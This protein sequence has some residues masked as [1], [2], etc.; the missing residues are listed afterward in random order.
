MSIYEVF[1]YIL[2]FTAYN[3]LNL[4]ELIVFASVMQVVNYC[5]ADLK[6]LS[7]I[8]KHRYHTYSTG[9]KKNHNSPDSSTGICDM[10]LNDYLGDL[11]G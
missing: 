3:N 5:Y 9:T 11:N 10:I 8:C 2:Y 1:Q 7:F 4:N 6:P